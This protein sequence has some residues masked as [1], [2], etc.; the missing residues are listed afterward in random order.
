MISE[1]GVHP[2]TVFPGVAQVPHNQLESV[3]LD[4]VEEALYVEEEDAD[5]ELLLHGYLHVMNQCEPSIQGGGEV[6]G[7]KLCG[8]DQCMLVYCHNM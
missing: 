5:F 7:A 6:A 3:M 1:E 8:V 4:M 2:V